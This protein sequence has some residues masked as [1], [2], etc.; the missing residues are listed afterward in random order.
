MLTF[1]MKG[2]VKCSEKEACIFFTKR[3]KNAV[4]VGEPPYVSP[5][6]I[7]F[8]LAPP[9][10]EAVMLEAEKQYLISQQFMIISLA[11]TIN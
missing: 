8:G 11:E 2:V 4:L 5:I 7:L 3:E 6:K 1:R 9:L 10:T